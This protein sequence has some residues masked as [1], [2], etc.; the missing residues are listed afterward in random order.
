MRFWL[1]LRAEQECTLA[2]QYVSF[3]TT[4]ESRLRR[5]NAR[6][7]GPCPKIIQWATIFL[8]YE[9]ECPRPCPG[10]HDYTVL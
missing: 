4:A 8:K 9:E 3:I 1:S 6:K 10:L 7:R 2:Y 5:G